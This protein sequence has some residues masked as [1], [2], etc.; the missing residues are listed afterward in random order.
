MNRASPVYVVIMAGGG[1]TR[2]WPMSRRQQPKHL[3]PIC[4]ENSML[5]ETYLRVH[6]LVPDDRLMVVTVAENATAVREALPSLV[7]QNV[8]SEPVGRGTAPCLGLAAILIGQQDPQATMIALPADHAVKDTA[9]FRS[10]LGAAVE[11]AQHGHLVTLGIHP[12]AP[13]TG[14]GYI[15][16]GALLRRAHGHEVYRVLR[17]TEKPNLAKAEEFVAS[18]RYYWNAG[19]FAWRADAF[20]AEVQR[21]MPDLHGQLLAVRAAL[22]TPEQAEATA[23]AWSG[24]RNASV[25]VGIMEKAADVVVIPADVG[26][27]DVG[28]WTS[29]SDLAEVDAQGNVLQGEHLALDCEDTFVRSSGRL[30]AAVGLRGMV[31][32][33]TGDAVLVCPKERVQDVKKLVEQL[34]REG[35]SRYL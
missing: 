23:R 17:F 28:S 15:E 6:D 11:A 13:E 1:G 32:I 26:W 18:G 22:G 12:H 3:L 31:V 5:V 25:D 21:L 8:V 30:V 4:G 33:D 35:K 24:L 2:L 29:V 20:L 9:S 14:Y 27:S 10:V 7:P 19:I 34:D 16:R